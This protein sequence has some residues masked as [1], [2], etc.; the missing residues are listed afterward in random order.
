MASVVGAEV[1][2]GP[3]IGSTTR[4]DVMA[5]TSGCDY[6]L[7]DGTGSYSVV[8]GISEDDPEIFATMREVERDDDDFTELD[9]SG[10]EAFQTGSPGTGNNLDVFVSIPPTMLIVSSDLDQATDTTAQTVADLA[11]A[12]VAVVS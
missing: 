8:A 10:Y 1:T 3:T 7:A 9:I 5:T 2:P 6:E 12:A 4:Q 11:R